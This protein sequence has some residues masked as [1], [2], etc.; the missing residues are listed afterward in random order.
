MFKLSDSEIEATV[1]KAFQACFNKFFDTLNGNLV[2]ATT[3]DVK[4][5]GSPEERFH[6]GYTNLLKTRETALKVMK[7]VHNV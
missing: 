6:R 7:E 1:D 2:T 5:Y 3:E 4:K